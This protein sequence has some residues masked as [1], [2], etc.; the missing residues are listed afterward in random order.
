MML[1]QL[2]FVFGKVRTYEADVHMPWQHQQHEHDV[3]LMLMM[4][5]ISRDVD[6]DDGVLIMFKT[7]WAPLRP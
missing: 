7:A 4:G 3:V 6:V 5:T 2:N 1:S